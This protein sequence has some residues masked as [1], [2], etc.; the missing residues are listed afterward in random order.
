MESILP[1]TSQFTIVDLLHTCTIIA[2]LLI[3]AFSAISLKLVGGYSPTGRGL[4]ARFPLSLKQMNWIDQ[5]GTKF[6]FS[7]YVTLN[8]LSVL[9]AVIHERC[10]F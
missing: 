10:W 5:K 9:W 2:I 6:I 8:I 1:P 4:S 7:A 3:I